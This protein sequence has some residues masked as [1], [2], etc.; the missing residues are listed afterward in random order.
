MI[1]QYAGPKAII[2]RRGLD[3]DNNKED[4][5]VYLNIAVQL[6]QA[7]DHDHTPNQI[8]TYDTSLQRLTDS[9]LLAFVVKN[10]DHSDM[11]LSSAQ[12]DAEWFVTHEREQ[13]ERQRPLM[14]EE[15]SR[16]WL[17]NIDLMTNYVI[18]RHFNKR[19][20][21]AI[22]DKLGDVLKTKHI[23]EINAPMYQKFAHVLHSIQGVLKQGKPSIDSKISIFEKEGALTIQL[24]INH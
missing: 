10:F 7:L 8:Y 20:Y 16:A 6:L 4:K 9:E 5:Y 14:S 24:I 1:I 2:S 18:Q 17:K 3:F 15:E 13:V 11:F 22:I 21:Y 12:K 19:I 23:T